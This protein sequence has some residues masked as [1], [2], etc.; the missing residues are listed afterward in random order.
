MVEPGGVAYVD[1]PPRRWLAVYF[2]VFRDSKLLWHWTLH[3]ADHQK[4]SG[5]GT[6]FGDQQACFRSVD[7]ARKGLMSEAE[8]VERIP[9]APGARDFVLVRERRL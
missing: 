3:S 2:V 4:L 6:G 7:R 1:S 5:S 9:A 8:V